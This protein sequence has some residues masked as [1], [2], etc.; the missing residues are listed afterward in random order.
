MKQLLS[1]S[2]NLGHVFSKP[3]SQKVEVIS[4]AKEAR[5]FVCGKKFI[6][7]FSI[8]AKNFEN[9]SVLFCE[10]HLPK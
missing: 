9:G 3:N 7:G 2:K 10:N 1:Y 4:S 6:D 8:T 5:C